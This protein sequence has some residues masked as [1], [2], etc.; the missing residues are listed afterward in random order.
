MPFSTT[1]SAAVQRALELSCDLV[2]KATKVDGVYTKD[3][4]K[5][6]DA[7]RYDE[8]SYD[9]ALEQQL[10]IMDHH[11]FALARRYS[12]VLYICHMDILDLVGTSDMN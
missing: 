11:A 10:D 1:D 7:V 8:I 2:I 12:M 9:E 3:P 4:N 5:F 6:S